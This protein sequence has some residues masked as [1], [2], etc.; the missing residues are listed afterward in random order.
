MYDNVTYPMK[1]NRISVLRF[2]ACLLIVNSHCGDLYPVSLLAVG[3]GQG[4][5]I[6]F[7]ISGYCLA[8]I[9]TDFIQWIAKRYKK[10]LPITVLTLLLRIL[11]VDGFTNAAKMPLHAMLK[12]YIDLYWFV[13]VIMCYYIVFFFIFK[14]FSK[15][16]I[17]IVTCLYVMAYILSYFVFLDISRFSVEPEG[18]APFKVLFYFGPFVCGG[19]IRLYRDAY[20]EKD[21]ASEVKKLFLFAAGGV[22]G[23]LIWAVEY[24]NIL[25]YGKG[26]RFQFLIHLGIFMFGTCLLLF[27]LTLKEKYFCLNSKAGRAI[28]LIGDSTLAIY[29][30]QV[31]FKPILSGISFPFNAVLFWVISICG[32]CLYNFIYQK[33]IGI[34]F[35]NNV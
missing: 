8:N 9:K 24:M 27:T 4:N 3:G 16:K 29:L 32:G 30:V 33:L 2:L 10:I 23:L 25:V 7:M 5:I 35:H 1:D 15:P 6:F 13:F 21:E 20:P 31:S 19:I 11:F 18:F 17:I 34:V 22:A 14:N 12:K 26:Y 28:E